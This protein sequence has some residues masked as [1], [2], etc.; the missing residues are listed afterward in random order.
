M[1]RRRAEARR[2]EILKAAAV[3]VA[4]QGFA[5]TR[6]ADVAT[7]LGVSTALVFY[8]FDTKD[9]LLSEAF[10]LAAEADLGRL[11]RAVGAGGSATSRLRAVLRLYAPAGEAPGWT[12]DIDAWAEAMRSPQIRAASRRIDRR[13]RAA[14][15]QV[16]L[17][18]VTAGE[19]R[20]TAPRDAAER[21]AAMLD[22]LAVA[23][24]VRRSLTRAQAAGW[25]AEHAAHEVGLAAADLAARRVRPASAP[26]PTGR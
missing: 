24:Q 7:E 14:I 15:E 6:V 3:V 25:A 17:D 19:F 22:G 21:I 9:R 13:W 12:L 18:G 4:R 1:V 23:T 5:R 10:L 16:V 2:D 26:A 8:H 11:D 20:C